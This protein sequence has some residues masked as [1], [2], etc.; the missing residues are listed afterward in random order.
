MGMQRIEFAGLGSLI[1]FGKTLGGDGSSSIIEACKRAG[2]MPFSDTFTATAK[3][4]GEIASGMVENAADGAW[5]NRTELAEYAR[6]QRA[7]DQQASPSDQ[8][9]ETLS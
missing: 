2:A 3:A 7:H 5:D 9:G 6:K 1:S 8:P 4:T